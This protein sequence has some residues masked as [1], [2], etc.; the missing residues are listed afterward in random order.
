MTINIEEEV[1]VSFPF[2]YKKLAEEVIC[3]AVEAEDF[4]FEAEI[5]LL[6]VSLEGIQEIN[7]QQ[8]NLD[9]PTDVLSF[10]MIAYESPGD[11]T[12]VR[13]EDDNFNPDTGEAMLGD[14]V[15]CVD[16]VKEQA[17][18]FGHSEKREFSF[19]ILHSMLHLFGYDHMTKEEAEIMEKKQR[20]ILDQM[21]IF[22]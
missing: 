19:L 11:F 12:K 6:L 18:H 7:G 17:E 2:D 9:C 10:P 21:G 13:Q 20:D 3:G 1:E 5:G 14:I 8:R 16:K 4:P 22:R 15:L